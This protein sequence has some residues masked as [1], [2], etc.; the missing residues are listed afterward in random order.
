MKNPV[1]D[2]VLVRLD[3]SVLAANNALESSDLTSATPEIY[4]STDVRRL[5]STILAKYSANV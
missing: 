4:H 2:S 3:F 5:C 1:S